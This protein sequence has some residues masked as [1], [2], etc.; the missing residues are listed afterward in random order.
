[1]TAQI[2]I[3][4]D[5]GGTQTKIGL[6]NTESRLVASQTIESAVAHGPADF[7]RRC[8]N[9]IQ[10]MLTGADVAQEAV[11]GVGLGA[12]G[13]LNRAKRTI[14]RS[15]NLRGWE[16]V[17]L[18]E[19]F[20]QALGVAVVL[21]NDANAA[22]YGEWLAGS[23]EERSDLVLLTLGTG[24]GGG[25]VIDSRLLRGMY[26]NA[27]E[28]GHNIVIPEGEQCGCGQCGC[29][30]VY[31]SASAV[32][33]RVGNS[34][35]Q[36]E[37]S[38]LS[39]HVASGKSVTSR[40]VADGVVGGDELC[41]RVWQQACQAL[42]LACVNIEHTLEPACVL[43]GGGLADAGDLLLHPVIELYQRLRWNMNESSMHIQL[44]TLG[45]KAGM[46]G[47]AGLAFVSAATDRRANA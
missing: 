13:P 28:L 44:A 31:A 41:T 21:E 27:G 1:M 17:P 36:G 25:A 7:V 19:L 24:V 8:A 6:V 16:D 34:I 22:A 4:I 14:T 11:A 18:A 30:E 35:R 15:P 42:A 46:I 2:A 37:P 23:A 32:A 38:V 20:E 40:D 5:F 12:P 3:G 10:S 45:N 47:A 33:R 9:Q 29:L 26:G 43:L 39:H